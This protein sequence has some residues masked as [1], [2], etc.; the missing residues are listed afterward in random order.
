MTRIEPW[1]KQKGETAKEYEKWTIYR[2]LPRTSRSYSAVAAELKISH[3]AVQQVAKKWDWETR[4]LLWEA[5]QNKLLAEAEL[6]RRLRIVE[7]HLKLAGA[8]KGVAAAHI[9]YWQ[10]QIQ[11]AV[12]DGTPMP[13]SVRDIAELLKIGIKIDEEYLA[14]TADP[15]R[16]DVRIITAKDLTDDELA[17]IAAGRGG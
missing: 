13:F 10:R 8:F 1:D 3:Q 14:R 6:E 9:N 17:N 15:K 7:E 5:H 2:E 16:V 4:E 11:Q 12:E